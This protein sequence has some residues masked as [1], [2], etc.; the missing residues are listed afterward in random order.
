MAQ[1]AES[2]DGFEVDSTDA[3]ETA[4]PAVVARANPADDVTIDAPAGRQPNGRYAKADA[5][6]EPDP[7]FENDEPEPVA[8]APE[9]PKGKARNDPE[10]RIGKA[11]AAQREAERRAEAAERR[12]EELTAASAPREPE[13]P[14]PSA[15]E[16]YMAMPGAPKED[17]YAS[18]ADFTAD[19]ALFLS[20][21]RDAERQQ[22]SQR[23]A[24]EHSAN[25]A[26]EQINGTFASQIDAATKAEPEFLAGLSDEILNLPT[27][28]DPE[29]AR[30][31][32]PTAWHVIG[33]EIRRSEVAPQLMRHLS[34]HPDEL[35]RLATLPPR[36][37][38]RAMAILE[39]RLDAAPP[40]S[41][42]LRAISNARPP[43]RPER[44]AA[45]RVDDEGS[46]DESVDAHIRRENARELARRRTR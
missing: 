31:A 20:D 7:E 8:A 5:A 46:E 17:D 34:D 38:T 42:P 13:R 39:T 14:Q 45:S 28:D 32:H 27:F 4:A 35:Q 16:R 15:R 29:L 1:F 30:G 44:G 12:A 40:G 19:M 37:L 18:Y 10:A 22:A 9:K 2:S 25:Q 33:E 41:A 3:P 6:P 21:A 24:A 11:V 26:R 43:I 23:T 36:E